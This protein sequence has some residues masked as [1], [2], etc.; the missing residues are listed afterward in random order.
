[1]T[2]QIN[3]ISDQMHR[4]A[5][6]V[7]QVDV[8]RRPGL[9][10][11]ALK[12]CFDLIAVLISSVIV[13]PVILLLALGV[14]LHGGRPFFT[15]E[16]VGKGGRTFKMYKL[17]TMVDGADAK[18]AAYLQSNPEAQVEWDKTQKLKH[19][20]RVTRFGRFLRKSSLDELPQ[21]WNVL[22][23]DMSLVGPRPMMPSQRS[24]YPGV[25]YYGLRPGVTGLWQISDRN[26]SSF[27]KRAEFDE[28]YDEKVS[29]GVDLMVL[30]KTV[31]SVTRGTGY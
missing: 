23:G 22:T 21:L 19:D 11:N 8:P 14:V 2:M 3:E 30:L 24:M 6:P 7:G 15:N 9:Y 27:A 12:R 5:S 20:P 4:K 17:K 28:A 25:A 26:A 16:R 1:M 13:I 31:R 10:R 18:L 29:F